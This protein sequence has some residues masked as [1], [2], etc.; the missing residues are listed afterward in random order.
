M[1]AMDGYLPIGE[2]VRELRRRRGLSQIRLAALVDRSEN[3]VSKVERGEIPLD[4][5]S[6]L[7]RV[8]GALKVSPAE[9]IRDPGVAHDEAESPV[10]AGIAA[11]RRAILAP[12]APERVRSLDALDAALVEANQMWS[13]VAMTA[14]LGLLPGLLGELD[15]AARDGEERALRLLGQ[16]YGFTSAVMTR[17]AEHDL[18]WVAV[19]R[20]RMV[21]ERLGDPAAA[22]HAGFRLVHVLLGAGRLEEAIQVA[23]AALA[24]ADSDIGSARVRSLMG[25]I[26]LPLAV[27][28]A[29]QS[30]EPGA[31]AALQEAGQLAA[32]VPQDVRFW[33]GFKPE[34][35]Q[36]HHVAVAVDLGNAGEA[37]RVAE[38]IDLSKVRAERRSRHLIDV[39]LAHSYRRDTASMVSTL[40]DVELLAPEQLSNFPL[41][42][43]LVYQALRRERGRPNRDLHRIALRVGVA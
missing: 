31:L 15:A 33:T 18:A 27:T 10:Q 26:H 4:R 21:A 25:A 17:L 13:R 36:L 6:V 40:L 8:A 14:T 42:R 22:A 32:D 41:V 12:S 5:V 30:D 38:T 3:W 7:I 23:D 11:I 16:G 43:E 24:R 37:L 39:A 20:S 29:R 28:A 9:L 35:V 1:R 2:R 34:N 19:E